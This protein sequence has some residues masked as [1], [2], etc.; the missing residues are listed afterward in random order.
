[1]LLHMILGRFL[2]LGSGRRF[3]LR[4]R[5]RF[6][7]VRGGPIFGAKPESL[8]G[9][10]GIFTIPRLPNVKPTDG[11]YLRA[12]QQVAELEGRYSVFDHP[13][14][15][16]LLGYLESAP[17][18]SYKAAVVDYPT[19][20]PDMRLDGTGTH[21]EW[22]STWNKRLQGGLGI[23]IGDGKLPHYG[24]ENVVEAYYNCQLF[25]GINFTL[26]YQLAADPAYNKDRG[27]I[28]I[29]SARLRIKF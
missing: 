24:P 10:L 25:K 6:S 8:G 15:V 22:S 9:A 29:F 19:G 12:W 20:M 14:K 26:D 7:W 21:M 4:L 27:P 2:E 16:L 13:G 5:R 28:N 1:M 17:M 3:G 23:L 18:G 11:Q